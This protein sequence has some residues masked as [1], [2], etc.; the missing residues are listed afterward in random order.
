[1]TGAGK[2]KTVEDAEK[3]NRVTRWLNDTN[4]MAAGQR[5]VETGVNAALMRTMENYQEARQVYSDMQT[6]T[7]E[8]FNSM[9]DAEYASFVNQNANILEGVD[10]NDKEAVSNKIAKDAA[11]RTFLMDYA[12]TVFDVIQLNAL[13]NPIK[14]L[15]NMRA[16]GAINE[17]Q[18]KSMSAI[19]KAAVAGTEAAAEK[20]GLA[21]TAKNFGRGV[22][23]FLKDSKHVVMAEASEGVEE[24][25]NYIAQEE[26]MHYGNVALGEDRDNGFTSRL[27]S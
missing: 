6:K 5:M 18:R 17:A 11:D 20:A 3:L 27:G 2:A 23:Q 26:G 14:L 8:K 16:S 25:I 21:T 9:S 19:G 4:T 12:N 1:M 15:K 22:A 7:L 10:T 24:A 13:R